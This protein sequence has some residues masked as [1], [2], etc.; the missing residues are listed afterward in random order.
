MKCG[1]PANIEYIWGF[2]RKYACLEHVRQIEAVGLAMGM[3]IQPRFI[4]PTGTCPNNLSSKEKE[5]RKGIQK[6]I[7]DV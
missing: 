7:E 4:I 6:E 3:P 5:E 1:K 2:E